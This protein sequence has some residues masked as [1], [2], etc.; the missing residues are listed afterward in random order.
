MGKAGKIITTPKA[1]RVIHSASTLSVDSRSHYRYLLK[2]AIRTAVDDM[3]E[4]L[5]GGDPKS[6]AFLRSELERLPGF[7]H[8][9]N[10][11]TRPKEPEDGCPAVT[12]P[13]R[14]DIVRSGQPEGPKDEDADDPDE[15]DTGMGLDG[16]LW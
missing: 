12:A 3:V 13:G 6:A 9:K 4:I 8:E 1:V 10:E 11:A 2:R 7:V 16:G 14:R 5:E 15:V